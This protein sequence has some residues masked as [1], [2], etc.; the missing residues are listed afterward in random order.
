TKQKKEKEKRT[1]KDKKLSKNELKALDRSSDK[2]SSILSPQN[3]DFS[4]SAQQ[5]AEKNLESSSEDD[6]PAHNNNSLGAKLG[7]LFGKLSHK[8]LDERSIKSSI[9][10]IER[11]LIDR[12]VAVEIA[13]AVCD[14]VK[15]D[16]LGKSVSRMALTA[17][18][19][20]DAFRE[21]LVRIVTPSREVH[22]LKEISNSIRLGK[23][24]AI[25]FV[26]VNGVGKSTTLS[27]IANYLRKRGLQVSIAACD[28]FRSG[29]V[30]QLLTHAKA[31]KLRLF[32]KG[33]AK[34][35]SRV[36]A[37]AIKEARRKSDDAV[38][39]DTAGRM[40]NNEP[41]MRS[42][43][44]LYETNRPDLVLFVGEALVGNEALS[45]LEKFNEHVP[46]DGIV[47]TKFDAVDEKVGAAISMTHRTK[48]PIVF[49]GTGQKYEDLKRVDAGSLVN[50]LLN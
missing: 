23:P 2:N 45:Q 29:A 14:S 17:P 1:W 43:R 22:I 36:C 6:I 13:R 28:T 24:Y 38:L 26:G 34:D 32:H 48:F 15:S 49:L 39:I 8:Q 10:Q 5:T 47:L 46:I 4:S 27:K 9:D 16:L 3:S 18:I 37:E 31:L 25:A 19:V 50:T 41:L 11:I 33:Y 30:E 21:A 20:K 44:K 35:S 7:G 42:L 40:Q 12:N